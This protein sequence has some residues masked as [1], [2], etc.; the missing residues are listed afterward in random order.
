MDEGL[1]VNTAGPQDLTCPTALDQQFPG[2]AA[3]HSGRDY[4]YILTY[5]GS[6][7]SLEEVGER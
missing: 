4:P 2:E 3:T 6:V 1:V 7:R 5:E